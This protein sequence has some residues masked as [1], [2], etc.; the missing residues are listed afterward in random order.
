MPT[1]TT[2]ITPNQLAAYGVSGLVTCALVGYFAWALPDALSRGREG[3]RRTREAPCQ[4]L[5]PTAQNAVL[6]RLPQPAPDFALKT[7]DG[8]EVKLSSLRGRVVL[9]NFWA[10]WCPTCVVEE[11]SLERLA[12]QMKN[13]PFSLLA[14]SVDENWDLVRQHFPKGSAMTVLLDKDKKVPQAYGT[15]KFPESFLIDRDGNIRYFV[16]SERQLWH[17]QEVRSCIDALIEE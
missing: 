7:H 13:K 4:V 14:V 12:T 16:V 15:E 9:V 6:G 17:T 5:R 2:S 11:P 10:T 3:V 1:P 8:Q